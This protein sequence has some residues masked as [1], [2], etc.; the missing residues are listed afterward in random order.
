MA[1]DIIDHSSIEV[2]LFTEYFY[3]KHIKEVLSYET[4]GSRFRIY[5]NGCNNNAATVTM[6][7]YLHVAP[8]LV[9][10]TILIL[11]VET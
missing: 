8:H 6:T 2:L 11:V 4:V 7:K 3:L 10:N 5:V 1:L 9:R